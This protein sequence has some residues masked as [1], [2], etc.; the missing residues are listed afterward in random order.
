MTTDDIRV[1]KSAT[2]PSLSGKTKLTFEVGAGA[3]S[4]I[5]VRIAKTNGTGAFSK[6]WVALDRVGSASLLYELSAR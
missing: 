1:L 2:C 6:D 5:L 3:K 4:E